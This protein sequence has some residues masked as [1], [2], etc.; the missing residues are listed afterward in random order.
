MGIRPSDVIALANAQSAAT[1]R[2]IAQ[3][4]LEQSLERLC[5]WIF[6]VV[7]VP[8]LDALPRPGDGQLPRVWWCPT[9]PLTLLPNTPP[10][11]ENLAGRSR[12]VVLDPDRSRAGRRAAAVPRRFARRP[13]PGRLDAAGLGLVGV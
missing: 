2:R 1:Q 10:A 9:G 7:I 11:A 13:V 12:R 6:D 3:V 4:D 8:I 5:G